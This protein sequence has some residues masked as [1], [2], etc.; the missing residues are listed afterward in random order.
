MKRYMQADFLKDSGAVYE[1]K[2]I[3]T[4]QEAIEEF[5]FL[6][7]RM[8]KGVSAEEFQKRFGRTI[9]ETYGKIL[10]MFITM[11]LMEKSQEKNGI[12]YRLTENGISVSNQVMCEFID[13]QE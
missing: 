1:E 7:L 3:V 9:E 13:P 12:Y 5:M 10:D 4:Y 8:M 11:N 6:G 2:H